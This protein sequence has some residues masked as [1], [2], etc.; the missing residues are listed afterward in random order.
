M[1]FEQ[2]VSPVIEIDNTKLTPEQTLR[3]R[4]PGGP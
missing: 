3:A 1:G 2:E 4:A